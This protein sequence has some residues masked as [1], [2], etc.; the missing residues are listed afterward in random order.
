MFQSDVRAVFCLLT[1][2][3]L[4]AC[5]H[6]QPEPIALPP[7]PPVPEE[8]GEIAANQAIRR[9][10]EEVY[11]ARCLQ[12]A[13]TAL[14]DAAYGEA[15]PLFGQAVRYLGARP[16]TVPHRKRAEEGLAKAYYRWAVDLSRA[17]D[18]F[19]ALEYARRAS[20]LKHPRAAGLIDRIQKGRD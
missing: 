17:G 18:R 19:Q 12:Q 7:L 14:A 8:G 16:A 1:C 13:E 10:A 2:C 6:R 9:G 4:A 11:G 5:T 3:L 15:A 20:A